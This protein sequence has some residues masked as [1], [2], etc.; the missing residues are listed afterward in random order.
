[1]AVVSTNSASSSEPQ[2]HI[3]MSNAL[4]GR[5]RRPRLDLVED[6]SNLSFSFS[7]EFYMF[8][9]FNNHNI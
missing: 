4:S 8:Y 2:V 7:L 9:I 1:M 6:P 5:F 3:Q